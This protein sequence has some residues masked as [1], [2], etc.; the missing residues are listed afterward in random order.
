M[1]NFENTWQDRQHKL[2]TDLLMY[3]LFSFIDKRFFSPRKKI[4][5]IFGNYIDRISATRNDCLNGQA[6]K[7]IYR[8][9]LI[10]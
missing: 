7:V 10:D 3:T 9:R 5:N 2:Y 1:N 6:E 4:T 8:G